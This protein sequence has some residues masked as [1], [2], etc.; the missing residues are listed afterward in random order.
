MNKLLKLNLKK[1]L[2]IKEAAKSLSISV[3]EKVTEADVLRFAL[4]GHLTLSV[5]FVNGAVAR[6]GEI[7]SLEDTNWTLI[8]QPL[9]APGIV[10][11]EQ[12]PELPPA[13]MPQRL[14]ELVRENPQMTELGLTPLMTSVPAGQ[15]CYIN[16]G[17][18]IFHISGGVWDLP[19]IGYEQV[20]VEDAYQQ[21]TKGPAVALRGTNG[22]FVR[23][24]IYVYQLQEI[25]ED[26][27]DTTGTQSIFKLVTQLLHG[28]EKRRNEAKEQLQQHG[29]DRT[30]D[31]EVGRRYEPAEGLP[32]GSVLVVRTSS[33]REF[34]ETHLTDEAQP[35][36]P[37]HASER[38]SVGQIIA[39]LAAMAKLDLSSEYK[40]TSIM[41]AAAA[42]KG[43]ELPNSNETIVKFLRFAHARD[44]KA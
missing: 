44:G 36:K 25:C 6:R 23:D 14:Q 8:P 33:L 3:G 31:C 29:E 9:N 18:E 41:R 21:K 43:L 37:L 5:Y 26:S 15:D 24:D 27:P 12:D 28:D 19:L 22:A 34:M 35:E 17:E 10:I 32:E 4:D 40:T 7:V 16:L 42:E 30:K 11:L 39:A 20:D 38:K 13:V 2:T 1:W